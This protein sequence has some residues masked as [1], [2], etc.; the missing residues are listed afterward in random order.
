MVDTN[1]LVGAL[2][3]GSGH[4]RGALRVCFER[5]A[6]PIV[7]EALFLEYEDVLGRDA[8]FQGCP[9]TGPERARL[10][11]DFLSIC[12]W[13]EVYYLWRPNLRDEGDNHVMELAVAG[14]ASLI[15]TN[16]V[17][18]FRGAELRFPSIRV[19]GPAQFK[20]ELQ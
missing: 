3:S 11:A 15:V 6:E 20:E 1:V 4:N 13:T 5:R 10:F 14:A 17:R 2:I 7:G 8:L 18:D 12:A 16:N 9:L 19:V